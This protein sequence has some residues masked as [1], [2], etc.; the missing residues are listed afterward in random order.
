MLEYFD[1][2]LELEC[3]GLHPELERSDLR[4]EQSLMFF[5]IQQYNHPFP[6][7]LVLPSLPLLS[8]LEGHQVVHDT[9]L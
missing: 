8:Y 5:D 2:R 3:F 1:L 7:W 4:L 9:L 6:L